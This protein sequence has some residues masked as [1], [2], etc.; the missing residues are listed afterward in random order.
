MVPST[1]VGL[2][3]LVVAV[4]PGLTYVLSFERQ[5]GSYGVTLA[6]RVLRF[7]VVSVVF[8][9]VLGWPEYAIYRWALAE[10]KQIAAGQFAALWIGMILIVVVPAVAGALVGGLYKTRHTREGFNWLRDRLSKDRERALLG[11]LLGR[12]PA[13]RAWDD[14][15][16]SRPTAY[17][18]VRTS[19]GTLLAGLFADR[20]YAA[21]F[22]QDPDLLLEEAWELAEDG[23]LARPLGYPLYIA[24]SEIAWVEIV[25]PQNEEESE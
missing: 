21:G 15:F 25:R 23:Q 5:V 9:L 24:A 13:P 14:Y 11:W 6:D 16:S 17:L 7:I 19:D 18:R 22:P 20:S 10:H 12:E 3:L 2:V 8:H 4:L 1:A